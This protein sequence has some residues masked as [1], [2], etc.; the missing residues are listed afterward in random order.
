ML[1]AALKNT[2]DGLASEITA[3]QDADTAIKQ[4]AG[5]A[6]DGTYS[7]NTGANYIDTAVSLKDADNK[8]DAA[9]KGVSDG[10]ASEIKARQDA[11]TAIVS[12][13]NGKKYK[14]ESATASTS[15][16]VTHNLGTEFVNLT[17]WV[18]DPADNKWKNDVAAVTIVDGNSLTVELTLACQVR[19][20]V[21][22][23]ENL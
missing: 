13:I 18:K 23:V 5:L 8:L 10:L 22:S 6:T 1:D 3:R 16:T 2:A 15:H 19:V 17:L 4:G 21:I 12:E 14:F 7:A 9:L 11:N 20:A